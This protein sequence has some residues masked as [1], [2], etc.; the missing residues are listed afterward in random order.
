MSAA[1][2]RPTKLTPELLKLAYSYLGDYKTKHKHKIPSIV[3]LCR[4]TNIAISTAY[5]WA[6]EKDSDFSYITGKIMEYQ[7]F[8][9]IDGGLDNTFNPT[10]TK[11]L[12]T[13]HGF[14]DKSEVRAEIQELQKV[15]LVDADD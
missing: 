15:E 7:Q 5:K 14:T 4:V 3:G 6:E 12:L 1:M 9:L 11:L 10:I 8:D 2:G 13:K